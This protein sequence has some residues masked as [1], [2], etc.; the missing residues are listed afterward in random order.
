MKKRKKERKR[1]GRRLKRGER[2][3]ASKEQEET[4]SVDSHRECRSFSRVFSSFFVGVW[5]GLRRRFRA[6]AAR[7]TCGTRDA[8]CRAPTSGRAR[9]RRLPAEH[10]AGLVLLPGTRRLVPTRTPR[11][12]HAACPPETRNPLSC[13]TDS[14]VPDLTRDTT[15][16]CATCNCGETVSAAFPL[17][18]KRVRGSL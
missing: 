15:A 7:R 13:Y 12:R 5:C 18:V 16:L 6:A 1:K 8:A 11:D 4:V 3:P 9:R 10:P 17:P 14:F 2:K